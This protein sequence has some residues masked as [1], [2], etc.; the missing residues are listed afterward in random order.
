MSSSWSTPPGPDPE[1]DKKRATATAHPTAVNAEKSLAVL[2]IRI[3]LE[4]G[5][6]T[7]L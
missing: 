4:S 2:A 6:N 1:H 5:H 7:A 3:L